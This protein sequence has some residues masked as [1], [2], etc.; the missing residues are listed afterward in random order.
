VLQA[1]QRVYAVDTLKLR[2]QLRR[3][4]SRSLSQEIFLNPQIL[5]VVPGNLDLRALHSDLRLQFVNALIA[6]PSTSQFADEYLVDWRV[7]PLQP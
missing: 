6:N 5:K 2:G 1:G 4:V 7:R 3:Q